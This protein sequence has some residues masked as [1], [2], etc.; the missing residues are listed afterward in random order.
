MVRDEG[1]KNYIEKLYE[2]K[3]IDEKLRD[4][5]LKDFSNINLM[6]IYYQHRNNRNKLKLEKSIAVLFGG[7]SLLSKSVL[8]NQKNLFRE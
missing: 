5:L 8:P 2:K 4:K 3:L 7:K 1:K 6:N